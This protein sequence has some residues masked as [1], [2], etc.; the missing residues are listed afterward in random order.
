MIEVTITHN[1]DEEIEV[2]ILLKRRLIA[3]DWGRKGPD[4]DAYEKSSARRQV[5]LFHRMRT[6]GAAVVAAYKGVT[7]RRGDRLVGWVEV[8]ADFVLDVNGL[9]GLPLTTPRLADRPPAERSSGW[10]ALGEAGAPARWVLPTEAWSGRTAGGGCE[11]AMSEQSRRA[12]RGS[13]VGE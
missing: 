1:L 11:A 7:E 2:D 6:E 12:R 4:P 9:L 3:L 13:I 5:K 10:A 8:G